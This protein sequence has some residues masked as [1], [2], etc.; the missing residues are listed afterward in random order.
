MHVFKSL[1]PGLWVTK[2]IDRFYLGRGE[3]ESPFV[4]VA[5]QKLPFDDLSIAAHLSKEEVAY[6]LG[7]RPGSASEPTMFHTERVL[8]GY[9]PLLKIGNLAQNTAVVGG[10]PLERASLT[11][12]NARDTQHVKVSEEWD[13]PKDW[14][15]G[16]YRLLNRFD[17]HLDGIEDIKEARC[18][19]IRKNNTDFIIPKMVIFQTFYGLNSR[20]INALCGGP[21]PMTAKQVISFDHYE[22]GIRT[23]IDEET[24][25]WKIVLQTGLRS[26]QAPALALLWFDE[27]ARAQA[28]ALF[29][30]GLMQNRAL[31]GGDGRSWFASAN[32]PHRI[33]PQ[34][35]QMDVVGYALRPFFPSAASSETRKFLVTAITRS[36]W[37]LPDQLIETEIANSNALGAQ[38]LPTREPKP[39][40]GGKRPVEADPDALLTSDEDPD[41][42]S[43]TNIVSTSTFEFINKPKTRQQVKD[44]NKTYPPSAPSSADDPD[45]IISAGNSVH[46]KERPSKGEAELRVRKPSKQLQHL[47]EALHELV[48]SGA[49]ASFE[50]VTPPGDTGL[51]IVRNGLPC[52]SFLKPGDRLDRRVPKVGWEVIHDSQ[53]VNGIELPRRYARCL[54]IMKVNLA[55][56]AIVLFEVE[57]RPG[58]SP[59]CIYAF[60]QDQE[61]VPWYVENVIFELREQQGRLSSS[62]LERVF[63]PLTANVVKALKHFY[64]YAA[65]DIKKLEPTGILAGRLGTALT[66]VLVNRR[67]TEVEP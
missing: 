34:S 21:W 59:F 22:S 66:R 42:G 2:W 44:T 33:G 30:D 63:E 32:I 55:E 8:A 10:L 6:T 57:P 11:L 39:F 14:S 25:A 35:F 47:V 50:P 4:H 15:V 26:D 45:S 56:R 40:G 52:W 48:L 3:A 51:L 1:P 19:V 64:A 24:G 23:A 28:D 61:L 36:S 17:F 5:L 41:A 18:L 38:Q 29:T 46:G 12:T 27:F 13:A 60:E 58:E 31:R 43:S 7:R 67:A 49:I 53:V 16:K 65:D 54:L 9:L 20:V 37:S 62:S